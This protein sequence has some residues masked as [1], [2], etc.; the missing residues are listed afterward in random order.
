MTRVLLAALGFY[1]KYISP[2]LGNNCRFFPS[3]SDYMR[4]AVLIHGALWG[5]ILGIL[6]LL[7][8]NP[9]CAGGIDHPPKRK[10]KGAL[11][12]RVKKYKKIRY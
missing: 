2:L 10:I 9:F 11:R 7:R 5:F 1:K 12:E 6:R 4:E 8:C 3:C